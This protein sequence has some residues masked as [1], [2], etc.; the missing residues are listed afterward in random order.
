MNLE[1]LFY[2][3]FLPFSSALYFTKSIPSAYSEFLI[4]ADSLEATQKRTSLT[5]SLFP[6]S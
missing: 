1:R 5:A 6:E 2:I 3:Q 4:K